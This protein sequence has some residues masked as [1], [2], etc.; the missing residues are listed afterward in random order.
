MGH[1]MA[2]A[3]ALFAWI[4]SRELA[5]RQSLLILEIHPPRNTEAME[6]KFSRYHSNNL[7]SL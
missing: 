2:L 4:A 6:C 1:G 5:G 3:A 7:N